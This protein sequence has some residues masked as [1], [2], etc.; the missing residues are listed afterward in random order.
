MKSENSKERSSG[1]KLALLYIMEYLLQKTDEDHYVNAAGLQRMLASR[2]L[3]EDRRTIYSDIALL[4]DFG[5]DILK[6]ENSRT[7]GWYIGARKY[8]LPEL[9]L[10]AD[11]V[12]AARFITPGKTR[13]LIK[14]LGSETSEA[15]AK[16]LDRE[17]YTGVRF[18]SENESIFYNVDAIYEAMEKNAQI[19]FQY[20]EISLKKQLTLKKDGALYQMSPWALVWQDENYYLIAYDANVERI[21]HFRV[22]KMRKLK[23]REDEPR[24]GSGSFRDFDV[25][26]YI[27][28]TF[29]MYGGEDVRVTLQCPNH[30]AGIITERFGQNVTLTPAG[31][32]YFHVTVTVSKS[33]QFFGWLAG[34]GEKVEL[35]WPPALRYEYRD[36]LK[37]L[38]E[39]HSR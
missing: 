3:T 5:L 16:E 30:F 14:K 8:E 10:L 27:M 2:G 23:V 7:G 36:Y 20:G 19:T 6:A 28:K 17:I 11:A 32:D 25:S 18:K 37:K 22:D 15:R 4:T 21:K 38:A 9:K 31:D 26:G 1:H 12:Q 33:P 34:L 29:G 13:Q 39:I 35:V 24:L